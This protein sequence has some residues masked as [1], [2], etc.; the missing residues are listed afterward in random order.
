MWEGPLTQRILPFILHRIYTERKNGGLVCQVENRRFAFWIEH[1]HIIRV[2]TE[3]AEDGFIAYL[4]SH[5]LLDPLQLESLSSQ[6]GNDSASENLL[7]EKG[8]PDS[9]TL[10]G[11]YAEYIENLLLH[12]HHRDGKYHFS[13][14]EKIPASRSAFPLTD[15][16]LTLLRDELPEERLTEQ[17]R[18]ACEGIPLVAARHW[19]QIST[20]YKLSAH[21]IIEDL[22]DIGVK[23]IT[24]SG[25]GEPLLHPGIVRAMEYCI[26]SGL[27]YSFI[28]NGQHMR[29]EIAYGMTKASWIRVSV[30]YW[31][32]ISFSASRG[33]SDKF[34]KQIIQ[35]I[36]L[37]AMIKT[38]DCD[39]GVN[40][41][42]TKDNKDHLIEATTL[43]KSLGVENVRFSPLW[44]NDFQA[45]H[46][47][48]KYDVEWGIEKCQK[49]ED[50]SF[51]V[52]SSYNLD[53]KTERTYNKC[54]MNQVVPVIGADL[55][56]YTCHNGSYEPHH[57]I[58]SIK[59]QKFSDM[60]FSKETRE[61]FDKFEPQ[62]TCTNM[63]CASDNKNILIRDILDAKGDNFI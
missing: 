60:W 47:A 30:D 20:E 13:S 19:K 45:Y 40:F 5:N 41:I 24:L 15:G 25:G 10:Q 18:L 55:N 36:A 57:I 50:D 14:M 56:T 6:K 46:N 27:D 3:R 34:F 17:L 16:I 54:Y 32:G 51:K 35:N 26:C 7:F 48:I 1:P 31:D 38:K 21:E 2:K 23:A 42:V 8:V 9:G 28:T 37:M 58:G 4:Q 11:R 39:L 22:S 43:L 33:I 62:L 59:N 44:I 12:I 53:H 61:Y 29:D 52:Y 49:L 63:Q